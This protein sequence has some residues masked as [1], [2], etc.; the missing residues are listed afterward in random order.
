MAG[1]SE[2][3]LRE[4]EEEEPEATP[5]R[6]ATT[7]TL[8]DARAKLALLVP[9][10]PEGDANAGDAQRASKA[11]IVVVGAGEVKGNEERSE[12]KKKAR[13]RSI[14]LFFSLGGFVFFVWGTL[15]SFF[16]SSTPCREAFHAATHTQRD[17]ETMKHKTHTWN[18]NK[19]ETSHQHFDSQKEER[20]TSPL[21]KKNSKRQNRKNTSLPLSSPLF[22]RARRP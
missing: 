8:G 9:P 14:N 3:L 4:G 11:A 2:E 16:F 12:E 1:E 22:T 7:T 10:R 20:G 5:P 19:V 6:A 13:E 18:R 17:F 21:Q 15:F